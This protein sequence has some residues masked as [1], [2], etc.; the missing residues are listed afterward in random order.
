MLRGAEGA[1]RVGELKGKEGTSRVGW[2]A[3]REQLEGKRSWKR[4]RRRGEL[5][6][7]VGERKGAGG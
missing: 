3:G 4:C 6:G 5:D 1:W 2:G 7:N